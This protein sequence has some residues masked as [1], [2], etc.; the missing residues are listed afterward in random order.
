M[1]RRPIVA[2]P[3]PPARSEE[4]P[5]WSEWITRWL[6]QHAAR[7]AP[8]S[9][10]ERLEEEWLADLAERRGAMARLRFGFGCCWATR[11]IAHEYSAPKVLATGSTTGNKVMNAYAQPDYSL[12]S[13][14]TLAFLLIVG[15]HG[16][17]IFALANGLTHTLIEVIPGRI[18]A[19]MLP[20]IPRP[21]EQPPP[22]PQPTFSST[23]LK[24]PPRDSLEFAPDDPPIIQQVGPELENQGSAPPATPFHP[25]NRVLGG[26]GKAFPNTNDF[27]PPQAI[28]RGEKGVATV[29]AC[30]DDRG[31]LTAAPTLAKTSGSASL[32]DGALKLA[33]A[34][35]GHYRA[36]TEDGRP[37]SSCYE[38]LVRFEF[39]D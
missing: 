32:D 21:V 35:S 10:S 31:R 22:I 38:F 2:P 26:P 7:N 36:T 27:Y 6:I 39:K 15:L 13:R 16:I 23:V 17:L 4:L 33:K 12:F 11:V 30:V 14:R 1:N 28:R 19:V 34:G 3:S 20:T 8:G 37:V 25:V 24:V 29:N 5:A 18:Q 9:L